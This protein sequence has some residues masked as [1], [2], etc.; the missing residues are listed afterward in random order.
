MSYSMFY[1]YRKRHFT[2]IA[3]DR[4]VKKKILKQVRK[5]LS[6]TETKISWAN[7]NRLLYRS[8]KIARKLIKHYQI[9]FR[10]V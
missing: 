1:A 8:K 9:T 7:L 6:S 2:F 4:P 5:H 3:P 10:F